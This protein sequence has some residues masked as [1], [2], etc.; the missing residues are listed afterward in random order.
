VEQA[1][2]L[3]AQAQQEFRLARRNAVSPSS[4]RSA[5]LRSAS[6]ISPARSLRPSTSSRSDLPSASASASRLV[7]FSSVR[8]SA[9]SSLPAR[10]ASCARAPS[11]F[12]WA[13]SSASARVRA[14]WASHSA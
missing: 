3:G 13:F 14:S 12:D 5:R 11:V 2:A 7:W 6:S 10:D 4:L 8:L 9:S 1:V